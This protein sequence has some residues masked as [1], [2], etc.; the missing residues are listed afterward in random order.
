MAKRN[1]EIKVNQWAYRCLKPIVKLVISKIFKLE[2]EMPEEVKKLK[3]PYLLMP[4]HQGFWDPFMAAFYIHRPVF[5]IT[6]DAVFRYPVFKFFVQL[7]G[8][9]PKTKAKSDIDA[10]KNI[11]RI[12]EKGGVIGIF[13]EGRRTWDGTTLPLVYSTSK[14]IRML[15][16][17]VVTLVFKGGFLSQP[18]WGTKIQRGKVKMEYKLLFTEEDLKGAKADEIH[19]KLAD[20]LNFD[21]IEYQRKANIRFSGKNSAENIEQVIFTC[22]SCKEIGSIY[23]EGRTVCCRN[24]GYK[25]KQNDYLFFEQLERDLIFDNIR[26]WNKW[27]LEHL[28]KYLEEHH[29]PE[30]PEERS[31]ECLRDGGLLVSTGYKIQ[32]LKALCQGSLVLYNETLVIEDETATEVKTFSVHELSGIN[33]QNREILEFYHDNTLYSIKSREKKVSAY[34]WIKALEYLQK[35]KVA[36][37]Q[38]D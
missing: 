29:K 15:K 34:K 9:I 35:D 3:P 10:L 24:C 27:Q 21:E 2:P 28:E 5:F 7:V 6:S 19:R 13:P 32:K 12:K 25:V 20:A 36:Q 4:T 30:M 18:R 38:A 31:R 23:S 11:I 33:V 16:I 1:K 26:D 8:A 37:F 17:P 14:L 22:P